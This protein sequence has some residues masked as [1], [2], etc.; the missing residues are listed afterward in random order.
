MSCQGRIVWQS[1]EANQTADAESRTDASR[2]G[3]P[4][5]PQLSEWQYEPLSASVDRQRLM[6]AMAYTHI[7]ASRDRASLCRIENPPRSLEWL[8]PQSGSASSGSSDGSVIDLGRAA[9]VVALNLEN[10]VRMAAA[11]FRLLQSLPPT[12]GPPAGT[13]THCRAALGRSAWCWTCKDW[14]CRPSCRPCPFEVAA[15]PSRRGIGGFN[16]RP[17]TADWHACLPRPPAAQPL[18]GAQTG[19]VLIVDNLRDA[20]QFQEQARMLKKEAEAAAKKSGKKKKV[21]E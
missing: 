11:D 12:S 8:E 9:C 1:G 17:L 10:Q 21:D 16:V 7:G 20:A 3:R 15:R 14:R 5:L 18:P 19:A 2:R 6:D 13:C 4:W